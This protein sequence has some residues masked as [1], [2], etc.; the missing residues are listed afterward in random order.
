MC[1]INTIGILLAVAMDYVWR[2]GAFVI[3]LFIRVY[4]NATGRHWRR[5][6]ICTIIGLFI[7]FSIGLY[8][9]NNSHTTSCPNPPIDQYH[10]NNYPTTSCPTPPI[11][12]YHH[13]NS[14]TPSYSTPPIDQY[15]HNK[16]PTTSCPTAPI[17]NISDESC[18]DDVSMSVCQLEILMEKFYK[19]SKLEFD[20]RGG[21]INEIPSKCLKNIIITPGNKL[22]WKTLEKYISEKEE[23][24]MKSLG[25][26]HNSEN[27]RLTLDRLL[28]VKPEDVLYSSESV[29][30]VIDETLLEKEL[31]NLRTEG[32]SKGDDDLENLPFLKSYLGTKANEYKIPNLV[33]FVW[34]REHPFKLVDYLCILS[35]LRYQK[36][37]YVLIHGDSEP[38][39]TYWEWLKAEAGDKLKLIKKSPPEFIFDIEIEDVEHQ[40]DVARLQILL[41]IGGIYLDTDTMVLKSLDD[42]RHNDDIVL[43]LYEYN[44]IGNAAIL[45][46]KN[47]F[48]LKKWFL[49]YQNFE[50]KNKKLWLRSSMDA[51]LKLAT[52]F[53]EEVRLID[54]YMMRPN[55]NEMK[56]FFKGLIDWSQHWTVHLMPRQLREVPD[57]NY[58][59]DITI[60]QFAILDS[61]YGEVARYVLWGD[62]KVKSIKNWIMHPDFNKKR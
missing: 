49:E 29:K 62:S 20:H 9:C 32:L 42:L 46:N 19:D 15:Y 28:E 50:P 13:N 22:G 38:S 41:Q 25:A 37:D 52:V 4:R 43:G 31:E 48:L 6:L 16:Y 2:V 26:K 11:D 10:H 60:P 55:H 8:C 5:N 3:N 39:G 47:S 59:V 56:A 61:T 40:S 23:Q 27:N 33:H 1:N 58:L 14:S 34:F 36:P 44:R 53:P 45:A 21:K 18:K 12:Q 54:P 57:F 51:P 17:D 7:G 30:H 24:F 35:A